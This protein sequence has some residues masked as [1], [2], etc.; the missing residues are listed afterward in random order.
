MRVLRLV[1]LKMVRIPT[2]K[3]EYYSA[4]VAS[5]GC[6]IRNSGGRGS[7]QRP[8][9]TLFALDGQCWPICMFHIMLLVVVCIA[10]LELAASRL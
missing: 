10:A 3:Y 7:L 1:R 6:L 9:G 2:S 4:C 8:N 5:E